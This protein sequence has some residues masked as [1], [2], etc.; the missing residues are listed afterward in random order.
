[1][2]V[3][4]TVHMKELVYTGVTLVKTK[5]DHVFILLDYDYT[6]SDYSFSSE[7]NTSATNFIHHFVGCSEVV[8]V[9]N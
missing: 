4:I 9:E 3:I 5:G 1:M 2:K 8:I 6:V 7:H